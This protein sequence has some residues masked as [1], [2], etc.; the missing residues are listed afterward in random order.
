MRL[1][2][3]TFAVAG[4]LAGCG[5]QAPTVPMANDGPPVVSL[6][7]DQ[8]SGEATFTTTFRAIASDPD[9]NPL[10][11]AW[12][13]DGATDP[14]ASGAT[15]SVTFEEAGTYLIAVRVSDGVYS[16]SASVRIDVRNDYRPTDAPDVLVIGFAG[17]CGV[18]ILQC[19]PPAE[20]HD[21]LGDAPQPGTMVA[22][23]QA[24]EQLGSTTASVGFRAHVDDDLARGLGY[25]AA[26]DLVEYARDEWIRDFRDPTRLV[27]VAH[28]HGT[29]FMSLLAFD[30]PEVRYEYAVYLDA[31]CEL[32]DF[33]H[34]EGGWFAARYG[35][36]ANFPRPLDVTGRAC[37]AIPVPG[38]TARQH[39]G[40]VVPW[41]VVRALEVQSDR[42]L[43]G[44]ADVRDNRRLDGS[45]GADVG[46]ATEFF[47]EA[48]TT[49]HRA[50]SEAM[51]WVV[52]TILQ[53]GLS[54]V[55]AAS[56]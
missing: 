28:S 32:W 18:A 42:R 2:L 6:R 26:S 23:A 35:A 49:V 14:S 19:M 38:V 29:Q 24:F 5:A 20:N 11:Y 25:Q 36:Q 7:A 3:A 27:L 47:A 53:N 4:A 30:H 46:I 39:I 48:H 52:G 56:E 16:V 51:S 54:A 1:A 34:V 40:D 8:A 45:G 33:D 9:G 21:Y 50:D 22:I 15:A 13:V 41:N 44:I 37:D 17:R 43:G 12:S 31:V 55:D 10:T